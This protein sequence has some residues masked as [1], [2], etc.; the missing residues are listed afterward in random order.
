MLSYDYS[1]LKESIIKD[2][3][4]KNKS[5]SIIEKAVNKIPDIYYLVLCNKL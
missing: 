2:L 4:F 1:K 3:K 5:A